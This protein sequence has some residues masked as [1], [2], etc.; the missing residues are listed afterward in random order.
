MPDAV[1]AS[2]VTP[3][4]EAL[5]RAKLFWE[6]ASEDHRNA[7][8]KLKAKAYLE[9]GYLSFQAALNALSV[10]CYLNGKFRLPNHSTAQM[11]A[12]CAGIDPRFEAVRDACEG[13]DAVQQQSPFGPQPDDTALDGMSRTAL[14]NGKSV[15][16]AVSGYLKANRRHAFAP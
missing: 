12:L 11:A 9:S 14:H 16:D 5:R 7:G 1:S 8:K 2:P 10:V 15:L 13:L 4:P 6:Q 3:T